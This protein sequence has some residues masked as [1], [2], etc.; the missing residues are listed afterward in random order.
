MYRFQEPVTHVRFAYG[1]FQG[2]GFDNSVTPN[3][4]ASSEK[5]TTLASVTHTGR[6]YYGT[7]V[8]QNNQAWNPATSSG[9]DGTGSWAST[10]VTFAGGDRTSLFITPGQIAYSD[11]IPLDQARSKIALKSYSAFPTGTGL[12][13]NGNGVGYA[14]GSDFYNEISEASTTDKTAS[15]TLN[16]GGTTPYQGAGPMWCEG[17]VSASNRSTIQILVIGDSRLTPASGC[18]YDS[19]TLHDLVAYQQDFMTTAVR[20]GLASKALTFNI[21]HSTERLADVIPERHIVRREI[22]GKCDYVVIQLGYNDLADGAA[23]LISRQKA[24]IA[25]YRDLGCKVIICTI[26]PSTTDSSNTAK[27]VND[28]ARVTF[29]N[30][31]RTNNDGASAAWHDGYLEVADAIE[32]NSSNNPV[33]VRDGGFFLTPDGRTYDSGT[34]NPWTPASGSIAGDGIHTAAGGVTGIG[35]YVANQVASVFV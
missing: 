27:G 3:L 4:A 19:T 15:G 7:S 14:G 24:L 8:T 9:S 13:K 5:P 2:T 10:P 23:K 20:L 33:R 18:L 30:Y 17:R 29:N 26:Y 11:W 22:A 21:T 12:V 34:A 32:T 35:L 16:Y 28:A 25:Q 6:V 1:Q 31:V